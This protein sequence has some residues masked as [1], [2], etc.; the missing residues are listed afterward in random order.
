M[1]VAIS[2]SALRQKRTLRPLFDHLVA[3]SCIA[4]GIDRVTVCPAGTDDNS[5][6]GTVLGA[7]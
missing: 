5:R 1:C 6:H 7:L 3:T 4:V 2:M